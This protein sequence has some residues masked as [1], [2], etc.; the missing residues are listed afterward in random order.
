MLQP[1]Q[2]DA[3]ETRW[4][5]ALKNMPPHQQ[6]LVKLT[7][8]TKEDYFASGAFIKVSSGGPWEELAKVP[9]SS[10][11][12]AQLQT[13]RD[14]LY[15]RLVINEFYIHEMQEET[16][17]SYGRF[18]KRSCAI[19][20]AFAFELQLFRRAHFQACL[21]YLEVSKA[22][23]KLFCTAGCCPCWLPLRQARGEL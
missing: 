12:D 3:M 17:P 5:E 20:R 23:G 21:K 11:S 4:Q 1:E 19:R 8:Y 10:L 6:H 14:G 22:L 16:I 15:R 13:L 18:S 9:V 7:G 2:P